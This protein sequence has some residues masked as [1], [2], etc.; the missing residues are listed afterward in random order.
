MGQVVGEVEIGELLANQ[1][2]A[3][4]PDVPCL[5][6]IGLS[7]PLALLR[8]DR[9]VLYLLF[10]Q[11]ARD[12]AAL[13]DLLAHLAANAVGQDRVVGQLQVDFEDFWQWQRGLSVEI[14][15]E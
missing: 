3:T 13:E 14:G 5:F 15:H 8:L 6:Q 4:L 9:L 7:N 1:L 10:E 2:L 11:L 12:H